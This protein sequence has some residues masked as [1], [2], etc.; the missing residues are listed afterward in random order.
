VRYKKNPGKKEKVKKTLEKNNYSG[1]SKK[2]NTVF[3][4]FCVWCF[5]WV[6]WVLAFCV[7]CWFVLV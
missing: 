6:R 7:L 1:K 2:K 5:A 3:V 4:A